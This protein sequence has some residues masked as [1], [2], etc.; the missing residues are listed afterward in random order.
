MEFICT[1][2]TVHQASELLEIGFGVLCGN[3]RTKYSFVGNTDTLKSL[4]KTKY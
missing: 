2:C 3:T 4:G 1:S